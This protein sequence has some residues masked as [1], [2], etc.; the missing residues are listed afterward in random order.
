M[1][2]EWACSPAC[3][4]CPS[5]PA[6][7]ISCGRGRAERAQTSTYGLDT[8]NTW[9]TK[10]GWLPA[11]GNLTAVVDKHCRGALSVSVSVLGLFLF[12]LKFEI[13]TIC[14][15]KGFEKHCGAFREPFRPD[16]VLSINRRSASW[17]D[18]WAC[19]KKGGENSRQIFYEKQ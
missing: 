10:Q 17:P 15:R 3:V 8:V 12:F 7:P 5:L 16:P 4:L 2:W 9:R 14:L 1:L 11:I 13:I 19:K 6:E 18:I